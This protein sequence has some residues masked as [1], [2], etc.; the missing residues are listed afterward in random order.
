MIFEK[1]SVNR[2]SHGNKDPLGDT[3]NAK[4]KVSSILAK[5]SQ[6]MSP[7]TTSIRP[8]NDVPLENC[9]TPIADIKKT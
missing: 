2:P 7:Q 3:G 9:C 8:R 4:I 1:K 6:Q 5:F